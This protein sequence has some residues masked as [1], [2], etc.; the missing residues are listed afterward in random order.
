GQLPAGQGGRPER[1]A[2]DIEGRGPH[3]AAHADAPL[4]KISA[5]L[6]PPKPNELESAYR[7][8]PRAG[9]RLICGPKPAPSSTQLAVPGFRPVWMASRLITASTMPAAPSV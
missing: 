5:Q 9:L 3:L 1:R 8:S 4:P 2:F 6:L 7:T